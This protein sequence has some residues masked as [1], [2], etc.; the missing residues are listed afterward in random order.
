[1]SAV[2]SHRIQPRP[3]RFNPIPWIA[4]AA[5]FLIPV[6]IRDNTVLNVVTV[7]LIF[8]FW[9]SSLNVIWGFAGQFSM[10]QVAL[11]G[12][13]AYIFVSFA[14][15][16]H[17]PLLLA[18]AAGIAASVVVSLVIGYMTMKL[19][20]FR[21]AIMTLAFALAGVGLASTLEVTGRTTGISVPADWPTI[22]LGFARWGLSGQDGGFA[23]TMLIVFALVALGLRLLLGR[24]T[25]RGLL[26]IREDPTLAQSLGVAANRFRL[27]A[28]VLSAVVAG[29]A[30]VFQAQY[31]K[32]IYPELFSFGTL[33]TVIVVL[34]LGGRGLILGP[35][36]GGL[37]YATLS[38]GLGIGGEF[39][40][41]IF[42][43]AII[44]ITIFARHGLAFYLDA[45]QKWVFDR[46]RGLVRR[47]AEA[48]GG[49]SP[50]VEPVDPDGEADPPASP[51]LPAPPVGEAIL[52]VE[53]ISRRY[54]GVTAVQD[55]SFE[56]RRGEIVGIIGPNGAGKTTLFN[57]VSG[58]AKADRGTVTWRGRNV[59]RMAPFRRTRLG[60]VRTFQQPRAF[61]ALSVRQNLVIAS[62]GRMKGRDARTRSAAVD[63]AIDTFEFGSSA[64]AQASQL[65][66]GSSKRFGVALAVA[67]GAELIMLDEP[68]AGLNSSEIDRFS[69]DLL[70]LRREGCTVLIVEHHM[71]LVMEVCDR[72]IVLDA[73]RVIASGTPDEVVADPA[74]IDAYL[75]GVDESA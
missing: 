59:T 58:F 62:E 4:A 5:L 36:V 21:F 42:G 68:A 23:V 14:G 65:S 43:A 16:L 25:G 17:W 44:A 64:D 12:V 18:I 74:V 47:P 3:G 72:L 22:D 10:A 50:R 27:L 55:V 6:L 73:G 48:G 51:P 37:L 7:G 26:A 52:V 70:R 69:D 45:G 30:G 20:G 67:T 54:G 13:S 46:L 33:V 11:G 39:E 41:M 56:V 15:S 49:E 9:A 29:L 71:D 66:Y 57:L 61:S 19:A 32:F 38:T 34:T 24:R 2:V 8:A 1:V 63:T 75:G 60:L 28:F 53:G 31:Y 35:L 40:G